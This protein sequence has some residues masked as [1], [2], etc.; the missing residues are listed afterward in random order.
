MVNLFQKVRIFQEQRRRKKLENQ[1]ASVGELKRK[2]ESLEIT[3]RVEQR[4]DILKQRITQA[5]G[6]SREQQLAA[7]SQ[8]EIEKQ[9]RIAKVRAEQ[10]KRVNLEAKIL[11]AK[12]RKVKAQRIVS[13]I[14]LGFGQQKPILGIASPIKNKQT[15]LGLTTPKKKKKK[16]VI[17]LKRQQGTSPLGSGFRVL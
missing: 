11:Q 12:A 5:K 10:L 9:Q 2:A 14:N 6:P 17:S 4:I 15:M 1:I 7:A 16:G 8:K 13:P 3:Q